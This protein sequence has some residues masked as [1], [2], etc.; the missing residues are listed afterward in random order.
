[1]TGFTDDHSGTYSV[2]VMNR[3]GD[4]TH[5][6][7]RILEGWLFSYVS[8]FLLHIIQFQLLLVALLV[9]V[10]KTSALLKVQIAC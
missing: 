2:T 5:S 4:I 1:M 10:L 6:F 9:L 3:A 7:Q 8:M